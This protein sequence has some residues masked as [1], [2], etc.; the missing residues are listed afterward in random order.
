MEVVKA[1]TFPL[2]LVWYGTIFG[3]S[4][5][6]SGNYFSILDNIGHISLYWG[7]TSLIGLYQVYLDTGNKEVSFSPKGFSGF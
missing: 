7:L 1:V 5:S 3:Q 2:I 4:Y 6:I